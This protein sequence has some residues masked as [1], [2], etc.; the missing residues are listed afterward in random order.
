MSLIIPGT[1]IDF[2]GLSDTPDS[3]TG[4]ASYLVRVNATATGLEFVNPSAFTTTPAGSNG[5]IQFND[6]GAFGASSTFTFDGTNNLTL[7]A[8]GLVNSIFHI[9]GSVDFAIRATAT[10]TFEI[11]DNTSGV[12]RI[13]ISNTGALTINAAYT[14]PTSDGSANYV[15]TTDGA[16]NVSWA[17]SGGGGSPGGT[18][19]QVQY[20][21]SGSFGGMTGVTWDNS[22]NELLLTA[23]ATTST[24]INIK[25]IAAQ[26]A[27]LTEWQNSSSVVGARITSALEFSNNPSGYTDTELFGSGATA[28]NNFCTVIGKGASATNQ[29]STSIG[30]SASTTGNDSTAI[31]A[32][33]LCG[34]LGVAIGKSVDNSAGSGVALGES[35]TAGFNG[36]A[37][38]RGVTVGTNGVGVGRGVT[39][40]GSSS[41]G[42]GYNA[43]SSATDSS[44]FG[45]TATASAVGT[46]SIGRASR[47]TATRATAFGRS[48]NA[49]HQQA[50]CLGFGSTSTANFQFV[51]GSATGTITDVYFGEGVTD[52]TATNYTIHGTGGTGTDNAGANIYIAGGK[53]TGNAAS[54]SVVLQS[55]NAGS[56]GTT[57]QTLIDLFEVAADSKIGM[58]GATPVVQ[59]SSTGETTGFSAGS[60]TAVNDDSTFTGNVG[61]TAYTISDVVKALKNIG[62]LAT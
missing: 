50:V 26:T 33:S 55:A 23:Q 44:A 22:I 20:N 11:R 37:I 5:E 21:N 46:T 27:N 3:Y 52:S 59:H 10:D 56:T 48:A 2:L 49:G 1:A 6:N 41:T 60:G 31:G 4:V 34:A 57:A 28:T 24:P 25:A 19:T 45:H 12:N 8:G 40:T 16:G 35:T 18:N 29:K 62:L 36:V 32:D 39:A 43:V 51:C 54:G 15:L 14:L 58:Y 53:A 38:G 61:S 13:S 42:V 47:A 30:E 7:D 17:A 9:N